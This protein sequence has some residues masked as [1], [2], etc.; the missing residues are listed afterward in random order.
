MILSA[1]SLRAQRTADALA[2]R[3]EYTG[4]VHYLRELYRADPETVLEIL[5][6]QDDETD[7]LFLVAHNPELSEIANLLSSDHF[8]KIPALGIASLTFDIG[9]WGDL[10]SGARGETEFFIYPKQFRYFMPRQ[11]R[12]VLGHP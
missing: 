10:A 7:S 5:S 6:L 4:K 9:S 2:K 12:A 11:I 8:G 3:L 1:A